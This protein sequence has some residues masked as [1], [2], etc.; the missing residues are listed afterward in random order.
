MTLIVSLLSLMNAVF[1]LGVCCMLMTE[2]EFVGCCSHLVVSYDKPSG[3]F[4]VRDEPY[5]VETQRHCKYHSI[6]LTS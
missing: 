3:V 4:T 6:P 1:D 5:E 2:F